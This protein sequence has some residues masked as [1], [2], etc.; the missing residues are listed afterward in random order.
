MPDHTVTIYTREDCH[1]CE[2]AEETVERVAADVAPSV[3]TDVVDVDSDP[4]LREE[5]GEKVPYVLVD[6]RPA[7][8]YRVDES[9]LRSR[10]A[11]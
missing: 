5:Y 11:A 7:F 3:A 10:L 4:A 6:G 9:A 2:E 8:K 1:L